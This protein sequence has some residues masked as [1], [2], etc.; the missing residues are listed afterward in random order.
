M[1]NWDQKVARKQLDIYLTP[2]QFPYEVALGVRGPVFIQ[3]SPVNTARSVYLNCSRIPMPIM[4]PDKHMDWLNENIAKKN[5][6]YDNVK[7]VYKF[8]KETD[9]MAFKLRWL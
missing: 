8:W 5:W 2:K 3:G 6:I 1:R 9:A 4:I 7:G